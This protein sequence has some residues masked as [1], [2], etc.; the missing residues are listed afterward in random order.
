MKKLAIILITVQ[1]WSCSSSESKFSNEPQEYSRIN[2]I[3]WQDDYSVERSE[4]NYT[5][6]L[7]YNDCLEVVYE[8]HYL[9]NDSIKYFEQTGYPEWKFIDSIELTNNTGVKRIRV[10]ANNPN[11]SYDNPPQSA[12][13]YEHLNFTNEVIATATTGVIENYKNIVIHNPRAGFFMSLFSFP[14]PSVKFPIKENN[15]WT[16]N[17]SYD[18]SFYGDSRLFKWDGITEMKYE[19]KYLGEE[20]INL[21]FGE[22]ATSKFEAIGTNGTITNRLTYHFNS[23]IGFVKQTFNTFDG[24]TIELY[25]VEYKDKCNKDQ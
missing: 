7:I 19:Y 22:V 16:W 21:K 13:T 5:D 8:Y 6:N 20:T 24:A 1:F 25:A 23:K 15:S 17:F 9:K 14:W 2:L 10:T 11:K 3:D 4:P 18:S 12:V